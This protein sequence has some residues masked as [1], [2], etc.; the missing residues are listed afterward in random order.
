M[1][2]LVDEHAQTVAIEPIPVGREHEEDA[3]MDESRHVLW[4]GVEKIR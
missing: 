2:R 3:A 1:A 4:E